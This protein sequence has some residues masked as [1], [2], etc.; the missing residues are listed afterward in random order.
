MISI[1]VRQKLYIKFSGSLIINN[2]N[3]KY[4][5]IFFNYLK[6]KCNVLVLSMYIRNTINFIITLIIH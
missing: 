2:N 1:I 3:K 4:I 6:Q 5:H